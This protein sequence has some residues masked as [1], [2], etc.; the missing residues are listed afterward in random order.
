MEPNA[1]QSDVESDGVGDLCD[2]CPDEFN[3]DQSD[4]DLGSFGSF[5]AIDE[6]FF[7][8]KSIALSDLDGDGDLDAIMSSDWASGVNWYR[9][10]DGTGNFGD[11]I[12]IVAPRHKAGVA[13]AHRPAE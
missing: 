7:A 1:D 4:A 10:L 12:R 11:P 6:N 13:T 2:N 9:N 8:P 5:L 3:A